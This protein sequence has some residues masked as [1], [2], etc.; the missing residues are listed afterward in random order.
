MRTVVLDSSNIND[1][2]V[3]DNYVKKYFNSEPMALPSYLGLF[4]KIGEKPMALLFEDDHGKVLYPFIYRKIF[5]TEYYDVISGYG[6]GG[7]YI[8]GIV[9]KDD[10]QYIWEQSKV[11]F[12]RNNVITEVIK[13][14]LFNN[15]YYSGTKEVVM[16]NVV[17][18]LKST[19]EEIF[20]SFDRKVR[21]NVKRANYYGLKVIIEDNMSHIEEFKKIY[22]ETMNRREADEMFYFNNEFF[23]AIE[24]KLNGQYKLFYVIYNEK[25]ISTELVLTSK[26]TIYSYLGGTDREYFYMRP[27]DLL[28]TEIIRWGKL[29]G[30]SCFILGG[31]HGSEDGIFSYKK[32]F[33]PNGLYDFYV[34]TRVINRKVYME[35]CERYSKNPYDNFVP[36]Y[37]G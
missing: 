8:H 36:A 31:G 25:V 9:N 15:Y 23:D 6:Y 12:E 30:H 34:G 16:K 7:P 17:C 21:K 13:F 19:M 4:C 32:S 28:K 11:W 18:S 3:W 5:D 37:R 1:D 10:W 22:Y 33:A 26:D 20:S 14:S 35:L 24:N 29:N 27:N 2:S